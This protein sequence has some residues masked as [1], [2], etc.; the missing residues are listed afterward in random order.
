MRLPPLCIL[1]LVPVL[2]LA[3]VLAPL[4]AGE[5]VPLARWAV[6][7]RL[8]ATRAVRKGAII[9]V[10]LLLIGETQIPLPIPL[11]T[12]GGCVKVKRKTA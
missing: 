8:V 4:A 7:A 9:V 12:G 3:L 5:A 6:A 10:V 1:S 2:A 11:G